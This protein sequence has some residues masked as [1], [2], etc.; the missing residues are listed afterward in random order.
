MGSRWGPTAHFSGVRCRHVHAAD[1][2]DLQGQEA[3]RRQPSDTVWGARNEGVSGSNPLVGSAVSFCV[4]DFRASLGALRFGRR[5]QSGATTA[6]LRAPRA[7]SKAPHRRPDGRSVCRNA[8]GPS[9]FLDEPWPRSCGAGRQGGQFDAALPT[10]ELPDH[11]WPADLMTV[12]Q[13]AATVLLTPKT[14]RQHH[15]RRPPARRAAARPRRLARASRGRPGVG[16]PPTSCGP[17]RGAQ[18]VDERRGA[19]ET[20]PL[21]SVSAPHQPCSFSSSR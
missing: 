13:V 12:S 1:P 3:T 2:R 14:V 20:W 7:L 21:R 6:S 16:G 19:P 15:P 11:S 4:R 8:A 5:G 9:P 10:A 17:S 18:R